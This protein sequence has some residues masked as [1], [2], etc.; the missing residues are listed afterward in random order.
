[1][2]KFLRR[3]RRTSYRLGRVLG[4]VNSVSHGPGGVAKHY[5]KKAAYRTFGKGMRW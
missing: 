2:F 3:T 1:M 4:D 5:A